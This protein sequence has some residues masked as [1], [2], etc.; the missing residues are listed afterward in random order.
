MEV[1]GHKTMQNL[2][3]FHYKKKI[4]KY[5]QCDVNNILNNN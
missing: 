5:W 2:Q 1:Y 4:N 3:A